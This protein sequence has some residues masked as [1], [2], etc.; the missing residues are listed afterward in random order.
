MCGS[1]IE[2][3]VCVEQYSTVTS[4]FEAVTVAFIWATQNDPH[5]FEPIGLHCCLRVTREEFSVPVSFA[6]GL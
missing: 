3:P 2:C 4:S 6:L 5:L 1:W